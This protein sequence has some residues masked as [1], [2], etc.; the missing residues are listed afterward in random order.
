MTLSFS[1]SFDLWWILPTIVSI[2]S[3]LYAVIRTHL[4]KDNFFGGWV[5]IVQALAISHSAWIIGGVCK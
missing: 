1:L 4:E 3:I 2:L 5:C